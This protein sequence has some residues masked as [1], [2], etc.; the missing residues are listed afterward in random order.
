MF[1]SFRSFILFRSPALALAAF[2]GAALAAPLSAWGQTA[3]PAAPAPPAGWQNGFFLQSADGQHRLQ[4]GLLVHAD[5][6]AA[7]ERVGADALAGA[8][9]IRRLRF[10][11]RGRIADRFEFYLNPD[12]A[13]GTLVVQDAYV[14]TRF[15]NAFRVRVGKGKTPFGHERLQSAGNLLFLERASPTAIAPNRDVGVQVLGDVAGG[16]FSYAVA[17]GNGTPD[18]GSV[19]TDT[20]D[21]KDLVARVVVRP[22][23]GGS[24]TPLGGFGVALAGSHGTQTGAGAL[25]AYRTDILAQT[26]F[27]YAGAVADGTRVRYS[28]AVFYAYKSVG[29]FG[30]YA[31]S[32]LPVRKAD[33]RVEIT[34][35]AWQIA[36]S[37]LVTG[38]S[39]GDGA[40]RPAHDFDFGQGHWGAFQIAARYHVIKVDPRAAALGLATAGS[41]RRAAAW[42][43]GLNWHL[44]PQL[45][46]VLNVER[47]VF[48]D[49]PDGARA[50]ETVVAFRTHLNF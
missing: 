32:D 3:A 44:N 23:A 19:E 50:P 37:V 14:D 48:D 10:S 46:Y 31:R 12:F 8:F 24:A 42:T 41:S 20:N 18:G 27:S 25:P 29:A 11:A 22:F 49:D 6:R 21:G 5:G 28:P 30:E 17:V 13:G 4:I 7:L 26:F 38:E 15:S 1:S 16:R 9:A 33:T 43:V 39:A 47:Y 34:H 2:M 36:G 35:D 45:K 40:V